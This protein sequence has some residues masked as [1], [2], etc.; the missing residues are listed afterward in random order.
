[1]LNALSGIV[2]TLTRNRSER[3]DRP[4][5]QA[6][7]PNQTVTARRAHR[8]AI[9]AAR[10]CADLLTATPKARERAAE[11]TRDAAERISAGLARS[12]PRGSVRRRLYRRSVWLRFTADR[13][14]PIAVALIV[15]TAASVSLA[16]ATPVGAAQGAEGSQVGANPDAARLAVG[17]KVDMYVDMEDDGSFGDPTVTTAVVDDGT[18]YKPVAVDTTVQTSAG[19][20]RHYTIREGDS[21]T[22]I[23]S[24]FGVSMMTVWWANSMTSKDAL[25]A[26][27]DLVI[28]PVNGLVVTVKA[29]D[30]LETLAAA[31]FVGHLRHQ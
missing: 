20:L 24:R 3:L 12:R 5:H 17:G 19:M 15:V 26:G 29:G 7:D 4:A 14:L 11:A 22:A 18:F 23:A 13:A 31:L 21:L 9:G 6:T 8:R 27:R 10:V 30:T 2:R 25:K 28:P 16:P 1:M